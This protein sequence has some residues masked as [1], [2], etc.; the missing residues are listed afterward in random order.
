MAILHLF[1]RLSASHPYVLLSLLHVP[2]INPFDYGFFSTPSAATCAFLSLFMLPS[3]KNPR[4]HRPVNQRHLSIKVPAR[5]VPLRFVFA[6]PLW[7]S[8]L[9]FWIS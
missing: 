1:G 2:E 5:L 9:A 6:D 8:F 7:L 3:K 4:K